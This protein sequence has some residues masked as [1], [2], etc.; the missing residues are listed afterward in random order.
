M[1]SS[2]SLVLGGAAT[3]QRRTG[4]RNAGSSSSGRYFAP[5]EVSCDRQ[6]MV[7]RAI[8]PHL[9]LG[10]FSAASLADFFV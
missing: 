5:L 7:G 4:K 3:R 10:S 9:P 6:E 2:E 1:T 8:A